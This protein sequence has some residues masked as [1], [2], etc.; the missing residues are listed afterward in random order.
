MSLPSNLRRVLAVLIML[1]ALL[2]LVGA[3]AGAYLLQESAEELE[4]D[5]ASGMDLGL[6]G[7]LH[8]VNTG[9]ATWLDVAV[10]TLRLAGIDETVE[11]LSSAELGRPASRPSYSVLD[12][13]RF[14]RLSALAPRPWYDALR[15]FW[16]GQR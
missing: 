1:V 16:E 12:T 13:T 14:A 2:G 8:A 15:D 11:P 5:L 6:E 3:L 10:E 7:I 4:R 9:S